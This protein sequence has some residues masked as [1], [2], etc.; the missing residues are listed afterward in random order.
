M[1]L[2]RGVIVPLWQASPSLTAVGLGMA[3]VFVLS[4]AGLVLDPRI[5]TGAPVWLKPAKFAV[6]TSI[7]A[8]SVAWIFTYL[9]AW[10]RLRRIVGRTTAVVLALE[11]ALI[12]I[13]AARGVTSHFNVG[14]PVDT[15][16]FAVMGI[17]ILLAWAVSIALTV[18]LF[19]QR[20]QDGA[21]GW[22]LRI[23][24]LTVVLGS[25]TGGLMTRPTTA[26]LASARESHQMTVAGAH[27]VGAPDGTPG[28][29]GTGW[30]REHGDL[31]VPHFLG[32]HAL[33]I[34]PLIAFAFQR[35]K[36]A[37]TR[38]RAVLVAGA[39]YLSLFGIL[40][41]QAL[42]GQPV[43]APEGAIATALIVWLGA[44][45]ALM[46][47]ALLSGPRAMAAH[48]MKAVVCHDA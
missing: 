28:M 17:A 35:A 46:S 13:Q 6:S 41:A 37:A 11:V 2:F 21:L 7:Y 5:V 12:D 24:M 30:S 38:Q 40:L 8:L 48:T 27:T 36:S 19:R 4:L 23:G 29:P 39:S 20:F 33:Q 34:L 26:Q 32:L 16:I 10:P 25:A 22:A 43:L 1:K 31:R 18:A 14:T 42:G 3:A 9:E 47:Y 44:T 45:I 15:A